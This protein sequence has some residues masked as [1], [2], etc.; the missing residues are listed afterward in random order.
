MQMTK[1]LYFTKV[2]HNLRICND[3]KFKIF[4]FEINNYG[5][6]GKISRRNKIIIGNKILEQAQQFN[7]L[8]YDISHISDKD[9]NKKLV[10]YQK[11]VHPKNTENN[12]TRYTVEIL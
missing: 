12:L 3:C 8:G 2:I 5:I 4:T 7:Y 10:R 1:Q 11:M 9:I 6:L